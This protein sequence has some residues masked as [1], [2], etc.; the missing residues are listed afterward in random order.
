MS[1]RPFLA[2]V[3]ILGWLAA[4]VAPVSAQG[5][6]AQ[7][8]PL[9]GEVRLVNKNTAPVPFA[10]YSITSAGG[11]L[12]GSNVVWRSISEFY[13]VGGDGLIDPNEEWFVLADDADELTEAVFTGSGGNMPPTRAISLGEIWDPYAVPF[14]D[15]V[16]DLRDDTQSIPVTVELALVGDY[17]AN[18]AVD[19]ADF[20]LWRQYVDSTTML[21][22]DGN[23]NGVVDY[24]DYLV[25]QRNFG[26]T[27]PLPPY[28]AG[29]AAGSPQ[30]GV[31]VGVPEPAGAVLAAWAL[32][33][34]AF[35]ARRRL[36]GAGR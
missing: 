32:G 15:L 25:W 28:I 18:Q 14:P 12:N 35:V 30:L 6:H 1:S 16:F 7:L 21:L 10:F 4:Y 36:R 13:D 34:F 31:I 5:L 8:F 11:A 26:A 22:S 27:L 9:T 24:A 33:W 3:V 20:I 29:S 17:S 2:A 23:L 19:Q